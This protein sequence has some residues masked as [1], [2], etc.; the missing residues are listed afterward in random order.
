MGLL[1][2]FAY[3]VAC[4]VASPW[5]VYRLCGPGRRD[6][7]MRFGLGLGEPSSSSIWLHGSSAGE[8]ALLR[9]LVA[10]LERD[11]PTTPLV[12][13]AFTVTGLAAA[14]KLYPPN[15][16]RTLQSCFSDCLPHHRKRHRRFS[17]LPDR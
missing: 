14:A 11:Y 6:L 7:A 2:D 10:L 3:L 8:V 5:L 12:V 4:I 1:L 9:P 16:S 13:S 17:G 15:G